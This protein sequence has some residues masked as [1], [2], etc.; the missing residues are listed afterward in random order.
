MEKVTIAVMQ[1]GTGDFK[2]ITEGWYG[3]AF[4]DCGGSPS[5]AGN[6]YVAQETK[7]GVFSV[8]QSADSNKGKFASAGDGIA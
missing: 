5:S 6:G 1:D 3:T 7:A 2:T 4:G 8:G